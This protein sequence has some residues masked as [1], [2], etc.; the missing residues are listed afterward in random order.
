MVE[1]SEMVQE[2][3]GAILTELKLEI[4]QVR[5]QHNLVTRLKSEVNNLCQKQNIIQ[6]LSANK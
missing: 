2:M 4:D 3:L 6:Q 5:D 1:D